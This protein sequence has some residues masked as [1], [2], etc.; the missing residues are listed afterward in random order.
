M[1]PAR[2]VPSKVYLISKCK[3]V[4]VLGDMQLH[5]PEHV[6]PVQLVY[7]VHQ[8]GA[9]CLGHSIIDNHWLSCNAITRSMCVGHPIRDIRQLVLEVQV[10][11]DEQQKENHPNTQ[12]PEAAHDKSETLNLHK[13]TEN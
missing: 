3:H 2:D 12:P 13:L 7:H 11:G 10:A 4:L 9:T 5:H 6:L 1:C 8:R